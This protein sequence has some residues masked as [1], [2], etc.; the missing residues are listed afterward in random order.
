[1]NKYEEGLQ[2]I[3]EIFGNG[4]DNNISLATVARELGT[5]EKPIPVV[6]TVDAYYEDCTFYV[7]TYAKSNKMLQIEQNPHVSIAGC[8]EMF[9]ATGVAKNLGWVL[10][11]K[12]AEIRSKLRTAFAA[13]Y[14]MANNENDENCCILAIRLVK[15][16]LNVNHWE[17]LY[18]MDFVNKVDM[19][20]GG[21]F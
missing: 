14:D 16:T 19:E 5:D 11:P 7:V 21:V 8:L 18:H 13:W 4:K 1:M 2:L 12:N 20:S 15:G 17:K 6:R 9:T 3:E 10:D